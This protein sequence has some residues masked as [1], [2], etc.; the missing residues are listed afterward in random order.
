MLKAQEVPVKEIQ[1]T[2]GFVAQVD[3]EEFERVNALSWHAIKNGKPGNETW[4]ARTTQ[5][6]PGPPRRYRTILMHR[7]ILGVKDPKIRIDHWNRDGSRGG[8]NNQ[9]A[10]LRIATPTQ[11][12]ANAVPRGGISRFKGV[13]WH[14][15][16]QCWIAQIGQRRR[17]IA[18]FF[19][20]DGEELAARAYD[21][22]ALKRFGAFARLNFPPGQ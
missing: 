13:T 2:R 5:Y 18:R 12:V 4:Y 6:S 7:F 9:R 3:D 15:R 14:K 21:A 19:G 20:K 22:E 10:N 16:D 17:Q 11:N 8:L 1:L